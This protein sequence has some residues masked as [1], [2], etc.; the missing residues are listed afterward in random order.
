M[1][2]LDFY[3]IG[4]D[5]L[6]VLNAVFELRLFRVFEAYSE[7]GNS[8]REFAS[9]AEIPHEPHGPYLMLY[10]LGT[11]PEPSAH[12]FELRPGAAAGATFRY[13]CE[14]WGLIQLHFGNVFKDDQLRWSHTNHNT[15]NRAAKWSPVYPELGDPATWEWPAVT[16]ASSKLNR[17]IRSMA[18]SKIGSHPVLPQAAE[19]ISRV[20]LKH[21][22]GTGIH[23][24]RSL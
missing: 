8:L 11:G 12:R 20:G 17:T 23:S 16:R 15:A 19:L 18:V 7:P 6:A 22:Y 3:A 1:P 5:Q 9:P 21:E 14:G 24:T 4:D 13:R 10:A 2:N